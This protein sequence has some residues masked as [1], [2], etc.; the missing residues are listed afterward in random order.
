MNNE[1]KD[2]KKRLSAQESDNQL[3]RGMGGGKSGEAWNIFSCDYSK[4]IYPSEFGSS[5]IY[6]SED[7]SG[8]K[9]PEELMGV[10]KTLQFIIDYLLATK[11]DKPV[12]MFDYGGGVGVSWCRLALNYSREIRSGRLKMVVSNIERNYFPSYPVIAHFHESD[13]RAQA[14][15]LAKK[16]NLVQWMVAEP[17]AADRGNLRSLRQFIFDGGLPLNGNVDLVFSRMSLIHSYVPDLHLHRLVELLDNHG[18]FIEASSFGQLPTLGDDENT[19]TSGD[20]TYEKKIIFAQSYKVVIPFYN[21]EK[22]T[23]VE[24]GPNQSK[25]ILYTILRKISPSSPRIWA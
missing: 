1:V 18:I 7:Y 12:I 8:R 14:F 6:G 3:Y 23:K 5:T 9:T 2:F 21:L 22:I 13:L 17:I 20:V 24:S 15:N 19:K 16:D 10:E 4:P 11:K 25:P